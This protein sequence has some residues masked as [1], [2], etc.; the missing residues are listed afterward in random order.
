MSVVIEVKNLSKEFTIFQ[1]KYITLKDKIIFYK[2]NNFIKKEVLKNLNLRIEKGDIIGIIGKNGSGK[3]TFLKILSNIYIPTTGKVII[4]KKVVSLLE[5]GAG[6]HSELTGFENIFMNTSLYGINKKETL[7]ILEKIIEFSE[8]SND[9]YLPVKNYSSGMYSRLAFSI[10]IH[11]TAEIIILDEILV[12]G[13]IEFQEKCYKKINE[14]M[15]SGKTILLVSHNLDIIETYCNK[16]L[17]IKK[18]GSYYF[19]DTIK[20]KEL[21]LDE[22]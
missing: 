11:L 20:A 2:K 22:K 13:D 5:L 14:L 16:T 10:A 12:V 1:E 19:G 3:S 17:Y 8:L 21:Y 18:D 7:K 4:N 9:I 6:F 15:N